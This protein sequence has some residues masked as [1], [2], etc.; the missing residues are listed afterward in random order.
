MA[1]DVEPD[2]HDRTARKRRERQTLTPSSAARV[3]VRQA[4]PLPSTH[5]RRPV[6][7]RAVTY[8]AAPVG[9][10]DV[11]APRGAAVGRPDVQPTSSTASSPG[12]PDVRGEQ[13]DHADREG[14][15]TDVF[16]EGMA[17]VLDKMGVPP[18]E[19][20]QL[21][22]FVEMMARFVPKG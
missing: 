20:A 8:D 21:D 2:H 18:E 14:A 10:P 3:V 6:E 15:P 19:R 9:R 16:L 12:R 22:A 5:P 17:D 1:N 4:T 13:G 11:R 7:L